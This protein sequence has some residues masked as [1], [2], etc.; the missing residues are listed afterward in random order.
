MTQKRRSL[1]KNFKAKVA[2]EA[3]R[4]DLTVAEIASKYNVQASQITKWK[5]QTLESLSD[6]F[7]DKRTKASKENDSEKKMAEL[8]QQI[9]Q[10]KVENDWLKKK[11][12]ELGL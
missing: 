3:I 2:L 7:E 11:S 12:L 9:G 10:L 6:I 8:Y 4:G 1:D 5:L